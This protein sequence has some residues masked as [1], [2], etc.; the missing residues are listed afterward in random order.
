MTLAVRKTM[1]FVEEIEREGGAGDDGPPLRRV[2]AC[3]VI[4]N[5]YAA[6]RPWSADLSELTGPSEALARRLGAMAL[7]A[8]GGRL[9]GFGK[10]AIVGTAG[11]QEHA[12]ACITSAFG[13]PLRE[14]IGGGKAWL[15]STSKRAPAGTSIDLPTAYRHALGVRSHYDTITVAIADA[16]LPDEIVVCFAATN[17]GRINE[18]LGGL[19]MADVTGNDGLR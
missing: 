2:A 17:R 18:R 16:P 15:P 10:G 7:D 8:L 19:R 13:D 5:P 12:V 6:P 14:A 9:E 4:T 1:L 11:E 3:A